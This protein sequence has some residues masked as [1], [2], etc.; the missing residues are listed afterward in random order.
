MS[1]RK[2]GICR[3]RSWPLRSELFVR[4]LMFKGHFSIKIFFKKIIP[5]L[6]QLQF[7][8]QILASF[9]QVCIPTRLDVIEGFLAKGTNHTFLVRFFLEPHLESAVR[10]T[11]KIVKLFFKK[12]E[13]MISQG[14]MAISMESWYFFSI[15]F[16]NL[17]PFKK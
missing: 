12:K 3:V 9:Y 7:Y 13:L 2:C 16:F 15:F 17:L 4:T 11:I 14:S 8:F 1:Q 10:L 5:N 6:G